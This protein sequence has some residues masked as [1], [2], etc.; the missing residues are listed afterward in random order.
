MAIQPDDGTVTVSPLY[1]HLIRWLGLL[2]G[3]EYLLAALLVTNVALIIGLTLLYKLVCLDFP[4]ST[5]R[6]AMIYV[7]AFPA[8]FFC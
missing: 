5:A 3:G 8:G 1:P 6:R 2:L 7:L 4:E